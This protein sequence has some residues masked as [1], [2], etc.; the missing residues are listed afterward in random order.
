MKPRLLLISAAIIIAL[1][2]SVPQA[3]EA[4]GC[5]CDPTGSAARASQ[6]EVVGTEN[7][8]AF[9]GKALSAA[10]SVEVSCTFYSDSCKTKVRDIRLTPTGGA[11]Y[12]DPGSL[13]V[14]STGRI[15]PAPSRNSGTVEFPKPA[16][17]IPEIN[18]KIPA[19]VLK[20]LLRVVKQ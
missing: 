13:N 15:L 1:V 7:D 6:C 9:S 12:S 5:R 17:Q 16:L 2:G 8:C 10:L 18:I 19:K 11:A 20:F 4:A 3:V 14:D